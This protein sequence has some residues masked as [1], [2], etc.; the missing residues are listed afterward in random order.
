MEASYECV[1]Y[2]IISDI[3]FNKKKHLPMEKPVTMYHEK[4]MTTLQRKAHT[5][6]FPAIETVTTK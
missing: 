4:C 1:Q 6:T 2:K 3:Y 5:R